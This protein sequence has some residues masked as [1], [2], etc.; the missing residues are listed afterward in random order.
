MSFGQYGIVDFTR[1]TLATWVDDLSEARTWHGEQ[2]AVRSG[3]LSSYIDGKATP[4]HPDNN[5]P[6]FPWL[7]RV[8]TDLPSVNG[9][10]AT[11]GSDVE[12]EDNSAFIMNGKCAA[13]H[14]DTYPILQHND[15]LQIP[16]DVAE[17]VSDG[18]AGYFGNGEVAYRQWKINCFE[19]VKGDPVTLFFI[20]THCVNGSIKGFQGGLT[21]T[22]AVCENTVMHALNDLSGKVGAKKTKNFEAKHA[23]VIVPTMS[24]MI[25]QAAGFEAFAKS[26]AK[27]PAT[28]EQF[29][30][31][32][33]L[34]MPDKLN[35]DGA[36][37]TK[38]E[39]IQ[40]ELRNLRTNGL[41]TD[42]EG[43]AGTLWGAFNVFSEFTTHYAASRATG[44][45][46]MTDAQ[47]ENVRQDQRIQNALFGKGARAMDA[48]TKQLYQW[49][50]AA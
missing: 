24:D 43:V 4:D 14:S 25:A 48:V 5:L 6:Y 19:V 46:K 28:D 34:V 11:K 26:L 27:T 15:M 49:V 39:N 36:N 12:G 41:G 42:I 45:Q 21:S 16:E 20:L 8:E 30:T 13:T 7:E 22:R 18:T 38:T 35:K 44:S 29:E 50:K 47:A 9:M 33:Q 17:L 3:Y 1:E 23:N 2:I 40:I 10:R 32:L 37:S 31:L